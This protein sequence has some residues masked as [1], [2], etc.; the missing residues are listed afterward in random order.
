[1]IN[2]YSVLNGANENSFVFQPVIKCLKL[3]TNGIVRVW[4]SHL[5]MLIINKNDIL[6]L[7]K[8]PT[9]GLDG[10]TLSVEA[11]FSINYTEQWKK[12]NRSSH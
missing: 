11:E 1:M 4:K 12:F 8:G 10:T 3:L 2:G 6:I 9:Q 7:G 5:F